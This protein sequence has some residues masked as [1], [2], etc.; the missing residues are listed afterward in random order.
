MTTLKRSFVWATDDEFGLEGWQPLGMDG[1]NSFDSKM[2]GHDV[3][4]HMPGG[5]SDRFADELMALGAAH[6]IR[7]NTG[8]YYQAMPGNVNSPQD[9]LSASVYG[10]IMRPLQWEEAELP[11]AP[12]CTLD[13]QDMEEELQE[14]VRLAAKMALDEGEP[15]VSDSTRERCLAWLKAGYDK[16]ER[17]FPNAFQAMDLFNKIGE[18]MGH[19]ARDAWEGYRVDVT[20]DTETM[21]FHTETEE[22]LYQEEEDHDDA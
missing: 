19:H 20:V 14:V 22:D 5:P 9:H 4:E 10:D 12:D 2:T 3:L 16:A 13:D 18:A 21:T 8:W 11:D 15:R 7:G 1:V 6:Y 17:T